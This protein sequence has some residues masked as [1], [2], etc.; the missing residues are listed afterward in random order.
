MKPSPA[1]NRRPNL[2]RHPRADLE[3]LE[4]RLA[5]ST[6]PSTTPAGATIGQS[7]SAVVNNIDLGG[8]QVLSTTD[9]ASAP[10]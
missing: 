9:F 8:I 10:A 2:R 4:E 5:L 6:T 7:L 1:K 3:R